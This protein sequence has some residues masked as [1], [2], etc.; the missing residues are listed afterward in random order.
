M[1]GVL[2]EVVGS[3]LDA[4]F[5]H[6][7][8]P[9]ANRMAAFPARD[10]E[11]FDAH[12]RRFTTTEQKALRA[13]IAGEGSPY[14]AAVL[15]RLDLQKASAQVA[16]RNLTARAEVEAVARR[17]VLVDPLLAEWIDRLRLDT[18]TEEVER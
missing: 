17:H 1:D 7:R 5:E 10:R 16:L 6:Q 9:E 4:F 13:V 14:R 3:D 18:L 12:W 8:E 15:R 11:A 2:R